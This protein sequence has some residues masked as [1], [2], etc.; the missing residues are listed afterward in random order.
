MTSPLD[1][2]VLDVIK[3][4]IIRDMDRDELRQ[5][6][7]NIKAASQP[8]TQSKIARYFDKHS[9]VTINSTEEEHKQA[10]RI[11]QRNIDENTGV[12]NKDYSWK[13]KQHPQQRILI[14][15]RII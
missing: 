8:S 6:V 13:L 11:I 2:I 3:H 14:G 5:R 4:R 1:D 12:S 15:D 9:Q 10:E 7:N